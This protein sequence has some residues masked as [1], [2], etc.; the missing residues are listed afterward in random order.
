MGK[1]TKKIEDQPNVARSKPPIPGPA[2]PPR[3]AIVP[4]IPIARPLSLGKT[5]AAANAIP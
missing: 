2:I 1:F 5:T 4:T 3:G